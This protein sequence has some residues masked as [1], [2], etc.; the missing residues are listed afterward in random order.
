MLLQMALFHSF[1][2]LAV[3]HCVCIY[4]Y[5]CMYVYIYIYIYIHTHTH[6]YIP[7]FLIQSSVS[8]HVGYFHVLAIVN[9]A[10]V[11]IG[12][13]ESFWIIV[14]SRYIPRSEIA[15]SYGN[16]IFSFLRNLHTVLHSS[17][18]NLHSNQQCRRVPFSPQPLQ[19][20]LLVDFLMMAI[21]TDVR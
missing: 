7:H 20:L 6:I 2:W 12:V 14:L 4:V 8:G 11:S 18:T 1:L 21:L 3:F 13:H 5:I 10:A 9:S 19:H 15:G 17:C 16:S